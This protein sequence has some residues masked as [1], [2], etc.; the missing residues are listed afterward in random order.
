MQNLICTLPEP[1]ADKQSNGRETFFEGNSTHRCP[2]TGSTEHTILQ[3]IFILKGLFPWAACLYTDYFLLHR[4]LSLYSK[5][6]L[7]Y[8]NSFYLFN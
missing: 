5:C 1:S 7:T 3:N 4:R 8:N 2:I 6:T